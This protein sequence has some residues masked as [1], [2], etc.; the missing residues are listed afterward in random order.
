MKI[1]LLYL[2]YMLLCHKLISGIED[3]VKK[4]YRVRNYVNYC[5]AE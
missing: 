1:R 2:E 3:V 4:E 5:I